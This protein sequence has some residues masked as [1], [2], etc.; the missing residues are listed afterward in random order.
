MTNII[1]PVNFVQHY[2]VRA[3]YKDK[4][5]NSFPFLFTEV[6]Q[7]IVRQLGYDVKNSHVIPS[8]SEKYSSLKKLMV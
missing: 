4:N 1:C 8:T 7:L 5:K 6:S 3:N 2:G